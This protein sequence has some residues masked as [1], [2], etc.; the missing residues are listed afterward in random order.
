M[1]DAWAFLP[2]AVQSYN[3]N[4]ICP[5]DSALLNL[6]FPGTWVEYQWYQDGEAMPNTNN[7]SIWVTEPGTYVINAFPEACPDY[8]YTSGLGPTMTIFDAVID[9]GEDE[10]GNEYFYA[11]P[12]QGTYEYQWFID[13]EPYENESEIPAVLWKDGLPAGVITVEIT[14]PQPCVAMSEGV[15]WDPVAA[16]VT[17][18]INEYVSVYPNPSK[19]ILNI[20]GLN[21]ARINNIEIYSPLGKMIYRE[22]VVNNKHQIDL[23]DR[24][25]GLYY[26]KLMD[27]EGNI[28][29]YTVQKL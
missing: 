1:L 26:I 20:E 4:E 10:F 21:E 9:Q 14:N 11:S 17:E 25:S 28:H 27:E 13:G 19:G 29:H 23:G 6:G 3:N 2:P 5:G 16:S 18:N 8:E 22:N 7:D 24:S 15:V 12:W